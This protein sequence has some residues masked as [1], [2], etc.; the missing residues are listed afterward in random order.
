MEL[1]RLTNRDERAE[2][3]RKLEEARATRGQGFREKGRS[4]LG[5]VHIAFGDLYAVY[6]ESSARPRDMLA[7]FIIHSLDQFPLTYPCP[8]LSVLDPGRVFEG[9]EL[10]SLQKGAGTVARVGASVVLGFRRAL[11]MVVFPMVKPWDLSKPYA[12]FRKIGGEFEWPFAETIDGEKI[13]A[14]A[15]VLD[16]AALDK[17]LAL[18]FKMDLEIADDGRTIRIRG[19]LDERVAASKPRDEYHR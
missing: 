10:W 5:E 4:V 1:H 15:M 17:S 2:F 19:G 9:G 3:A 12:T 16:G 18:A 14:Q 11:A 7:G 8:E 6:D 13:I